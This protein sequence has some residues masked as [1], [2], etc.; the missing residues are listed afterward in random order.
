[1]LLESEAEGHGYGVTILCIIDCSGGDRVLHTGFVIVEEVV[2]E[3]FIIGVDVCKVEVCM[4][5]TESDTSRVV[6]VGFDYR[7]V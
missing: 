4:A 7:A 6:F 1:M 5:E 2:T 3:V